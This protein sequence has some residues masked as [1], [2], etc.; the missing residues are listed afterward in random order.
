VGYGIALSETLIERIK[1][2]ERLIYRT[3]ERI[4]GKEFR[5]RGAAAQTI[6][7]G[8]SLYV[9][10]PRPSS[11]AVTLRLG[12]QMELPGFDLSGQVL[13]QILECFDLLNSG[14]DEELRHKIPQETYYQN[15]IGLAKRIAP[16]GERVNL[17]GLTRFKDGIET[18]VAVTKLQ[19][20]IIYVSQEEKKE[21]TR[22]IVNVTGRL[23]L[24]D[25]TKAR[26]KIKLIDDNGISYNIVVP[27][28]MMD[29]IV[30][31]LWDS[32]VAVRGAQIGVNIYLN[33]ITKVTD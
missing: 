22:K 4:L 24:A 12:R 23:L 16:D 18:S 3:V 9:A 29:D 2:F 17:V 26:R 5:A 32:V 7:E 30:K 31:P 6:Q 21:S 10:V 28:A 8:Y 1:D 14:Q 33:E 27:E 19:H 25:A 15:F 13:D 11:M 20:Q